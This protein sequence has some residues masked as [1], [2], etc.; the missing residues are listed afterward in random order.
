MDAESELSERERA[1]KT[2]IRESCRHL[3]AWRWLQKE[4]SNSRPGRGALGI[5]HAV[6]A[7][8][9]ALVSDVSLE[10]AAMT[11]KNIGAG[12]VYISTVI[13]GP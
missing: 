12:R 2:Y 10:G 8:A 1:Q 4:I 5:F 6:A 11:V 13:D 9:C 3:Q 7:P